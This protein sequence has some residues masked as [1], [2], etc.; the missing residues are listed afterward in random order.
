M[1]VLIAE[2]NTLISK[3]LEMFLKKEGYETICC[4]DGL[5]AMEKIEKYNPDIIVVDIMLP[6][7]SGLE[8]LGKVKQSNSPVPVIVTS[9]MG[10]DSVM[11]EAYG[12]GA[13]AYIPKPFHIDDLTSHI[14]ALTEPEAAVA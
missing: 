12:L 13:D 2:D 11:D 8:I 4:M 7:F 1:K 5:E 3:T 6:Y 14:C 10:Q 9:A